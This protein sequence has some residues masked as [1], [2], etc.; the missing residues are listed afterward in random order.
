MSQTTTQH[1]PG[2][3]EKTSDGNT[4]SA[5]APVPAKK[6]TVRIS[7]DV[8]ME[9]YARLEELDKDKRK[10]KREDDTEE[11]ES[12]D[13]TCAVEEVEEQP[14]FLTRIARR[15][16]PLQPAKK[17]R[18]SATYA[19][20][21]GA[22][23]EIH[24]IMEDTMGMKTVK[25][26]ID[27]E[28]SVFSYTL[29]VEHPGT[30]DHR[31]ME[32]LQDI[33]HVCWLTITKAYEA[34]LKIVFTICPNRKHAAEIVTKLQSKV[35]LDASLKTL[36]PSPEKRPDMIKAVIHKNFSTQHG[37]GTPQSTSQSATNVMTS[38]WMLR[39]KDPVSAYQ[40]HTLL[41]E[42]WWNVIDLRI[43]AR[44]SGTGIDLTLTFSQTEG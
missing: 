17:A 29:Y 8:V 28:N 7:D 41:E 42:K 27:E 16:A 23:E 35:S 26:T 1:P 2:T 37:D 20:P 43:G 9:M 18:P 33:E 10:R 3:M 34:T 38:T 5:S 32:R 24:A 14:D 21:H 30:I 39:D 22:A 31:Q 36:G 19:F 25:R 44:L 12:T 6:R 15:F 11:S 4:S 40:V 13:A